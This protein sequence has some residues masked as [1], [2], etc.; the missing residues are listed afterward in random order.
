[1]TSIYKPPTVIKKKPDYP[2][3]LTNSDWCH[4]AGLSD[5][6]VKNLT[7]VPIDE[8]MAQPSTTE[9]HVLQVISVSWQHNMGIFV[10]RN[11]Y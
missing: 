2:N 9:A 7:L 8:V 5:R 11:N 4:K 3:P 10:L 6:L 1:M